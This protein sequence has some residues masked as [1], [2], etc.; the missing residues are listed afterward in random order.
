M[1]VKILGSFSL[2]VQ[3]SYWNWEDIW[4]KEMNNITKPKKTFFARFAYLKIL[5]RTITLTGTV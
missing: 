5:D 2:K 4:R 3:T 1:L